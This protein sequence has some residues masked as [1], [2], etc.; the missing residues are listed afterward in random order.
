MKSTREDKQGSTWRDRMPLVPILAVILLALLILLCAGFLIAGVSHPGW[1]HNFLGSESDSKKE[2]LKFIGYMIGGNLIALGALMAYRRAKA[3]EDAAKAQA[4][5]MEQQ[6]KANELTEQGHRQ[7][8]LKN[9]IEHLGHSSPSVRMGGSSELYHL[10]RDSYDLRQ[11]ILDILCGQ[12]RYITGEHEY[13]R[14]YDTVP[15]VEIQNLI[16]LLFVQNHDVFRGLR[17]NLS[18]SWLNG[19]DLRKARLWYADLRLAS[20]KD[21]RLE[22]ACLQRANLTEAILCNGKLDRACLQETNLL[23]SKMRGASLERAQLQ[24]ASLH[25]ADLENAFLCEAD[26]KGADLFRSRLV[27]ANLSRASMQGAILPRELLETRDLAEANLQG[28]RTE[29]QPLGTTFED[30][31]L[32]AIGQNCSVILP[33]SHKATIGSFSQETAEGWIDGHHRY[34]AGVPEL[35]DSSNV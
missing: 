29:Y 3:M 31:I 18:G 17:I 4:A 2:S 10:A 11:T 14:D 5:G 25:Q 20:L 22:D 21:A 1:L 35:T 13:Q 30:R 16:S 12:I 32:G 24:G 27:W 33:H 34:M 15:S 19:A 23:G 6:A 9:G 7:E 26:L 28:A 8:R